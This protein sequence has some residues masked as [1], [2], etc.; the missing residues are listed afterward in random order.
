MIATYKRL[1]Y[2]L[3][4]IYAIK[5]LYNANIGKPITIVLSPIE[6]MIMNVFE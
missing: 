6:L 4:R 1:K 5:D 3:G 2:V